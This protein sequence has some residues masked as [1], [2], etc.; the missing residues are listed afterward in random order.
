MTENEDSPAPVAY[1]TLVR[2]N[3]NF[4]YLW[5]GQIVSLLGDWF[6]L[7]AV[8]AL[9]AALTE[10][11]LAVGGLFAVRM[12]APFLVSPVA[13]VVADRYNRKYVLVATDF[14]RA[15][16]V[17]GFLLVDDPSEVWLLYA[18]SA[19]QLGISGFFFP[20]R[21]AILPDIVP[22]AALGA[23]NALVSAT[24]SVMLALGAAAGGLVAGTW[25]IGPAFVIDAATFLV[26]AGFLTGIRLQA[27]PRAEEDGTS[28]SAVVRQYVDG[29]RYLRRQPEI[30]VTSLHKP[31]MVFCFGAPMQVVLVA[32]SA[33]VF[34]IGEGGSLGL[35]IMYAATGV[36]TGLGPIVMRN[37][38]QD[39]VDALRRALLFGYGLA[40]MGTA[41]AGS[42]VS[43][44]VV[45]AGLSL[46]GIG[47]GIL[48]VFSSQLLLQ[49]VAGHVRGRVFATE[50]ALFMLG[51][52]AGS[53]LGGEYLDVFGVAGS[54]WWM[55]GLGLVPA[56]LWCGWLLRSG[57]DQ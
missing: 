32:V 56:L 31:A 43:F 25:G 47:S 19:V 18:L 35:G 1:G 51:G 20:A 27:Q 26:S 44:P 11:G 2:D 45:L 41:I 42:L 57:R 48:W 10:S 3:A 55:A 33:N 24:W 39:R 36:G 17:C 6:N 28:L 38:T 21:S 29:L 8:A 50:H 15:I 53:A 40:I 52:A 14:A 30:A 4:R 5:L 46:R 54:M 23:A 13:G 49:Q 16:T 34:P 7:I 9:V 37:F 12:L 22:P